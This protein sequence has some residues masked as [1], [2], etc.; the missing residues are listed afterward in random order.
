MAVY[1]SQAGVAILT[2]RFGRARIQPTFSNGSAFPSYGK[3]A[4]SVF[5]SMEFPDHGN[6]GLRNVRATA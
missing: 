5:H 1:S 6:F 4:A 2:R 3:T